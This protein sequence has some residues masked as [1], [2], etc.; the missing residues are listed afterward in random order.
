MDPNE[1]H[2]VWSYCEGFWHIEDEEHCEWEG[3]NWKLDEYTCVHVGK[4]MEHYGNLEDYVYIYSEEFN[5]INEYKLL[6]CVD[7]PKNCKSSQF[8]VSCRPL[9]FTN[10]I[11]SEP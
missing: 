2:E 4:Y 1:V 7:T 9:I 3:G 10:L 8:L 11:T 6:C 5:E